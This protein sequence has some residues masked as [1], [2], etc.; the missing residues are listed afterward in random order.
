MSSVLSLVPHPDQN[1]HCYQSRDPGPVWWTALVY[2]N[3]GPAIQAHR[4][5]GVLIYPTWI[6]LLSTPF[7]GDWDKKFNLVLIWRSYLQV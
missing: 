3:V 6:S 2:I 5:E 1:L 4:V 7:Q